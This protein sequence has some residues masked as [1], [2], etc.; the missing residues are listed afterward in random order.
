MAFGIDIP[1]DAFLLNPSL[2]PFQFILCENK[3]L[4]IVK[5]QKNKQKNHK[6]FFLLQYFVRLLKQ[7]KEIRE[8]YSLVSMK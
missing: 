5:K 4:N 7:K 3:I 8:K 1:Q 2:I 6:N